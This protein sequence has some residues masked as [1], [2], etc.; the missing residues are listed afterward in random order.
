L[1]RIFIETESRFYGEG[2]GAVVSLQRTS[3]DLKRN[4]HIHAVSW[5]GTSERAGE[6][7]FEIL[8]RMSTRDVEAVIERTRDKMLA[9]LPAQD[10]RGRHGG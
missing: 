5:T 10:A 3:S 8:S 1:R 2:N 9:C 7:E 4:P 6:F